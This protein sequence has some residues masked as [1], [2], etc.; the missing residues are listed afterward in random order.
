M[1]ILTLSC[2][3]TALA[4]P[5]CGFEAEEIPYSPK[6]DVVY[7]EGKSYTQNAIFCNSVANAE[8]YLQ[9][10][11]E[12]EKW[13]RGERTVAQEVNRR[14]GKTVCGDRE[15]VFYRYLGVASDKNGYVMY[16][17]KKTKWIYVAEVEAFG[18]FSSEESATTFDPYLPPQRLY[19]VVPMNAVAL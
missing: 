1:R 5:L 9:V 15:Q 11:L 16:H 14:A 8:T 18:E 13:T 12:E 4:L 3:L 6:E 7:V 19:I 17:K 2:L 10:W